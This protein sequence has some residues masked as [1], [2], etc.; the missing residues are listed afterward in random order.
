MKVKLEKIK[1]TIYSLAVNN[2]AILALLFGSYARGT[3]TEHSEHPA[4]L[5]DET[6]KPFKSS[7]DPHFSPISD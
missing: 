3:E 5:I 7:P 4:I 6:D 2:N 1:H